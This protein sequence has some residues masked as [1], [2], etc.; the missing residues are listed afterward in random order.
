MSL[1]LGGSKNPGNFYE[2]R[3]LDLSKGLDP[4]Q[5]LRSR[6]SKLPLRINNMK[7]ALVCVISSVACFGALLGLRD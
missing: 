5:L 7:H 2:T 1:V 6:G 3:I 4:R